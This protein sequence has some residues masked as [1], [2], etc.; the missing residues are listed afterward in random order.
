MRN[1]SINVSIALWIII[2]LIA[3]F[4]AQLTPDDL[5][6]FVTGGIIFVLFFQIG[7]YGIAKYITERFKGINEYLACVLGAISQ[8]AMIAGIV[9]FVGMVGRFLSN[10][11]NNK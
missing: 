6:S 1:K 3:L 2:F 7:V 9:F 8:S 11:V 5:F 4:T 10:I